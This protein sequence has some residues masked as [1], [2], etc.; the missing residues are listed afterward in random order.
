MRTFPRLMVR[1]G[2]R[3]AG[4]SL[5]EIIAVLVIL[6]IA[7][8]MAGIPMFQS[9][10]TFMMSKQNATLVQDTDYALKRF[11]S[12]LANCTKIHKFE[13]NL[14][15]YSLAKNELDPGVKRYWTMDAGNGFIALNPDG[16]I[17][18][19]TG[20]EKYLIGQLVYT[21]PDLPLKAKKYDGTAWTSSLN[22]SA[23]ARFD[24]LLILKNPA[25]PGLTLRFET[26]VALRN[27]TVPNMPVP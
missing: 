19:V 12:E 24:I 4:F 23:L 26:T 2:Q 10:E 5:I 27:N 13:S 7:A 9:L 21:G 1:P 8:A 11:V 20:E 14:I 25:D 17:S 22:I 15:G 18:T 6:G 16:V 3:Q